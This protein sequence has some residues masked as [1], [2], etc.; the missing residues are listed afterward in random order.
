MV[1]SAVL[2]LLVLW[3]MSS[4]KEKFLCN[5]HSLS[6]F[7]IYATIWS[8]L[9]TVLSLVSLSRVFIATHFP[10]QVV[11]GTVTG[12]FLAFSVRKHS[13]LLLKISHS[14]AFS[15][16]WSIGM[17][18][19]TLF[20]YFILSILVYDPLISVTKAQ[21][22]CIKPSYIH[23]DTTPFYALVRD[24]GTTL[25]LGISFVTV[26][27]ALR[28][29]MNNWRSSRNIQMPLLSRAL[30]IILSVV[31]LQLLEV[32]SLPKSSPLLFYVAGFCRCALIP[33]IVIFVVP[34]IAMS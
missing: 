4:L 8:M 3:L 9:F 24:T 33:V 2:C 10:H 17:F 16:I 20:S 11:L 6:R 22:W 1:T 23:L 25:G 19:I 26:E 30:K 5:A 12:I 34:M 14:V 15:A 13:S 32:I 28:A 18:V 27:F 31:L 21:R 29:G 7:I